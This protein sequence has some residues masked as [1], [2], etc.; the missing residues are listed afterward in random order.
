MMTVYADTLIY[1][2]TDITVISADWAMAGDCMLMLGL[3]CG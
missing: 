1:V 2:L 3:L